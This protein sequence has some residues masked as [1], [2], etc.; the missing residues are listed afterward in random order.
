MD[1][2]DVDDA[3][4]DAATYI[5]VTPGLKASHKIYTLFSAKILS[6]LDF[7]AT[8]KDHFPFYDDSISI[9]ITGTN[10][11]STTSWVLYNVLDAFF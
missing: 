10:G 3:Q 8:Y 11:K 2:Q 5:V 6:E 7:L 9:G 1:D 4:L